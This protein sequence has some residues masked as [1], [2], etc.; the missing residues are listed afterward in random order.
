MQSAYTSILHSRV[1]YDGNLNSGDG[2]GQ[3]IKGLE[4][5]FREIY[6]F[7]HWTVMETDTIVLVQALFL[8]IGRSDLRVFP[9]STHL[10]NIRIPIE[11]STTLEGNKSDI[12]AFTLARRVAFSSSCWHSQ[13]SQDPTFHHVSTTEQLANTGRNNEN[14]ARQGSKI[15]PRSRQIWEFLLNFGLKKA[16]KTEPWDKWAH[17]K[18]IWW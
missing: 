16:E 10:T 12:C 4:T 5:N 8:R 15:G 6:K 3:T 11:Q 13:R 7:R 2:Y 9:T 14:W 17:G 18:G 1:C